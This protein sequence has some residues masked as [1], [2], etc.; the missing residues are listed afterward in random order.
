MRIRVKAVPAEGLEIEGKI[1]PSDIE[2]DIA[3]HELIEAL[4][5]SGRATRTGDDVIV[6]GRLTGTMLSQCGL[7]LG[8]FKATIDA[9]VDVVFAPWVESQDEQDERDEQERGD[10][11][12]GPSVGFS[13]YDGRYIDLNEEI[14]DV[15]L[16]ELPIR[17]VCSE[18]CK[19]LCHV[20]GADL[21][22]ASCRCDTSNESSPFGKLEE[23]REKLEKK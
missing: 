14:R 22:E 11:V 18:D 6:K 19:G 13:Y 20:C 21:N 16:V 15:L 8:D 2:L 9:A 1:D 23:L 10:E 4:T 5:F 3:G 17:P 7:C 12:V